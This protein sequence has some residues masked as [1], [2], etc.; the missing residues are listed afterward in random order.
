MQLTRYIGLKIHITTQLKLYLHFNLFCLIFRKISKY[1]LISI[2]KDNFLIE[3]INL[4]YKSK[5]METKSY[6]I[7]SYKNYSLILYF[8]YLFLFVFLVVFVLILELAI[9][10]LQDALNFHFLIF[11]LCPVRF[12]L[13]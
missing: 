11:K 6:L 1:D 13:N 3:N 12:E 8:C 9:I 10:G 7:N 5:Y 4:R 2:Y